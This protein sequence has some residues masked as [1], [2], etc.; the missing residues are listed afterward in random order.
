VKR[1]LTIAGLLFLLSCMSEKKA[2]NYFNQHKTKAA[3]YCSETFPVKPETIVEFIAVDSAGY[4]QAYN[5]LLKYAD[6]V[7]Q[8]KRDTTIWRS[9]DTVYMYIKADT[10]K[11]RKDI[12]HRLK[13]LLKPCIDSVVHI[14]ERVVD[15]AKVYYLQSLYDD[16]KN[17]NEVLTGKLHTRTKQRNWL[18]LIIILLIGWT[19]RKPIL[20]VLKM[21]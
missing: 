9:K 21:T 8:S 16:Q 13:Q 15:S 2:A 7:L 6:S 10:A 1:L 18:I 14:R 11:I 5:D 3:K 20:T 17:K 19:L 12:E 4:D